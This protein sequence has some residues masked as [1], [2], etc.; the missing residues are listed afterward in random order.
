MNVLFDHQAYDFLNFGGIPRYFY[1]LTKG[2]QNLGCVATNT[3]KYSDN[4]F[5]SDQAY[6]DAKPF[7]PDYRLPGKRTIRRYLNQYSS[8][9]YLKT[10]DFDIVHP[11][12]YNPYFYKYIKNKPSV[13]TF[14]DLIHEKFSSQYDF[15]ARDNQTVLNKQ[16]ILK[17]SSTLIAVSETTK[18]DL[19]EIYDIQPERINVIGL[20]NSISPQFIEK[21][22]DV[23]RQQ[24]LLYVG[25]RQAYKNFSFFLEA[26]AS[27]LIEFDL[28]LVCAGGGNF[29]NEEQHQIEK[30]SLKSHVQHQAITD[31]SIASL[32]GNAFAFVFPSLY[33]GFGIPVLEA[34]ACGCPCILS[35]GGSLPEVG[36]DGAIYFDPI[37]ADSL[38][39]TIITMLNDSALRQDC[40]AKGRKRL[41]VF[42]WDITCK[43]TVKL[44][45]SILSRITI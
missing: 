2:I 40:I 6:F 11:T 42:N 35:T 27:I 34:F 44:Y 4:V 29:N 25:N 22:A 41:D 9:N 33:E 30:M 15:L 17:S 14:H 39:N 32:Y 37:D 18:N 38:K 13:V 24:Y 45:Q 7:L 23:G 12:Y 21:K 5:C 19:I 10:G 28:L 8:I 3:I 26:V 20:G 31:T 1:E 16:E 36:G 43:Q